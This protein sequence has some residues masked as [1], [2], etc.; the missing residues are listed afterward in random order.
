A[1]HNLE[2]AIDSAGFEQL[3][4]THSHALA[5]ESLPDHHRDPFDR[6]LV[7]QANL[8]G[9]TLVTRDDTVKKY[10]VQILDA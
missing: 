4:I 7:A 5:I 9:C 3:A 1:P 8:E 10:P 6:L 2:A